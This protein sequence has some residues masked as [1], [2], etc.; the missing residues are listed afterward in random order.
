MGL[1]T[2]KAIGVA[3][4][5]W[6]AKPK[7]LVS[8]VALNRC[9]LLVNA[10]ST[11]IKILRTKRQEEKEREVICRGCHAQSP[12]RPSA[13]TLAMTVSNTFSTQA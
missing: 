6:W 9:T 10:L 2:T 12:N 3:R 8:I 5:I 11:A 7:A 4:R 1:A 13:N